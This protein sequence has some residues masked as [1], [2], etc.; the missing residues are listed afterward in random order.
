M[1]L[2]V[3]ILKQIEVESSDPIFQELYWTHVHNGV[4]EAEKYD[5]AFAAMEKLTGISA[6]PSKDKTGEYIVAAY[7]VNT[8]IPILSEWGKGE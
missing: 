6:N 7:E 2:R 4:A 3:E 8:D 5:A 1:K